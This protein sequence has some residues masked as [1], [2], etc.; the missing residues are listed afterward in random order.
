MSKYLQKHVRR[1]QKID[2]TSSDIDRT[3]VLRITFGWEHELLPK[4]V[5]LKI[6]TKENSQETPYERLAARM[7]KKWVKSTP[8]C[9]P[10]HVSSAESAWPT[11][12]C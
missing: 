10:T 11:N 1:S 7:Y 2:E 9:L 12:G 4:S 5:V 3:M 8:N 6:S